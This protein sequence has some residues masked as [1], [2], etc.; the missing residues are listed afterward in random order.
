MPA[1]SSLAE[2][3]ARL[4][5]ARDLSQDELAEAASVGVDTVGRIERGERR[6][7]RPQT[8]HKLAR[9]L[10]VESNVL[11]GSLLVP[12]GLAIGE[13]AKL[14][15]AITVS[16][17]IPGLG[18]P[19]ENEDVA[20]LD[21]LTTA[22][23]R[24]WSDYVAGRFA[25][26]LDDLPTLLV[27]ARRLVAASH[28]DTAARA[29]GLLALSY[30]LGAG[31][32][33]RMDLDD[34]AWASAERALAAARSSDDPD[35]EEAVS[36]RYLV[37]VL[38]RQGRAAEASR[39]A[40]RAAECV[41]PRMLDRDA[42]RA[43]IFGNLLFNAAAASVRIGHNDQAREYLTVARAAAARYGTDHASEAAI[44]GPRVVGLQMVELAVRTGEPEVA[45][46]LARRVPDARGTVPRFWEAGHRLHLAKATADLRREGEALHYLAEARSIAPAW[47]ARQSLGRST[48]RVL[49]DRAA[50]RRGESFAG[51]AAHYGVVG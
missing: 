23:R 32:A 9:A 44:F 25:E 16:G 33:G 40:I 19:A 43:G 22:S 41:E 36:L 17:E 31:V 30:R 42:T 24:A 3:L 49:V 50:R 27:D 8:L 7:V 2:N 34:L 47:A 18:D 5:K 46:H 29:N 48:M 12:S 51:L 35:L 13:T 28:G 15:Q 21:T 45:L 20:S 39:V 4:R 26:L 6:T 38:I 1:S 10:G 11:T 14:R 37:W